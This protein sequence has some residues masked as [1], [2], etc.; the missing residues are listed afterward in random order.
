MLRT[1]GKRRHAIVID[2]TIY[3]TNERIRVPRVMVIDENSVP[4][5]DMDTLE[6]LK[7][8]EEAGLDLVEVNPKA[9]P[10][11]CKILDYGQFQYQQGRKAQ[12]QR[13]KIKKIDTKGIRLSYKI[14]VHD[15]DFKREQAIKFLQKGDKVKIEMILKGREKQFG[16]DA[17]AKLNAFTKSVE[18]SVPITIESPVKRMGGQIFLLV[19]PKNI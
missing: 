6:A 10:P 8:A 2:K 19:A 1:K 14:G 4:R 12:E 16:P 18:E 13:A 3:R 17:T 9:V 7:L 5:G 15:L 11:I